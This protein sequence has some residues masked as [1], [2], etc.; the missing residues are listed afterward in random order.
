MAALAAMLCSVAQ[1]ALGQ[2]YWEMTPYEVQIVVAV[3]PAPSLPAEAEA[4]LVAEL[5]SRLS[6]MAGAVCRAEVVAAGKMHRYRITRAIDSFAGPPVVA[7]MISAGESAD[8]PP[9]DA[10]ATTDTAAEK[11]I[12][13][14]IRPSPMGLIVEARQYDA[15]IARWSGSRRRVCEQREAWLDVAW[16]TLWDAFTPLGIIK[17]S[18]DGS[19]TMRLRASGLA[20]PGSPIGLPRPGQVFLPVMRRNDRTGKPREHGIQVVP[21]TMLAVSEVDGLDAK[22]DVHSG[23]RRPLDV[24]RR[25]RT[26]LYGVDIGRP[27]GTTRLVLQSRSDDA[28]ALAGY[29]IVS[30]SPLDDSL[31]ELGRTDPDGAL[32]IPAGS[33]PLRL[34][35][36]KHGSALL[37]KVPIAP[38]VLP[39]VVVS[40]PDD[41]L[42][43]K[44]EGQLSGLRDHVVDLAAQRQVL[45]A[46]IRARIDAEDLTKA[47]ELL[48]QLKELPTKETF[49]RR[50]DDLK[51]TSQVN[52]G[53]IQRQIDRLFEDTEAVLGRYITANP[54]D[55]LQKELDAAKRG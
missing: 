13:L 10:A 48:D 19:A 18:R 5:E 17:V 40:I 23:V 25:A 14:G 11:V 37:G 38:G 9:A 54:V 27:R 28:R 16:N 45:I 20:S 7:S 12:F 22:L 55:E 31:E 51:K 53:A 1:V 46:R 39:E 52:D 29:T 2:S 30:R 43:L 36:I 3:E 21:W 33:S 8:E 41:D 50:M 24:G 34:L 32:T 42:R 44:I 15:P 49:V 26:E 35:I 47:D 6:T 4:I